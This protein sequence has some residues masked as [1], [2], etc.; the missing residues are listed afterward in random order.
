MPSLLVSS[1]FLHNRWIS[2][3]I[4]IESSAVAARVL[5]KSV[6]PSVLLSF[7]LE[8]FLGLAQHGVRGPCGVL[9]DRAGFFGGKNIAQ[10][11]GKMGQKQG[12]FEFIGKCSDWFFLNLVY[13]V[14]LYYLLYSCTNPIFRKNRVPEIWTKM[15]LANQIAGFFNQLYL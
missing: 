7:C 8:V 11:M 13:K 2:T 1:I 10:K 5:W 12:F 6:H 14:I 3:V 4:F 15:L 9:R